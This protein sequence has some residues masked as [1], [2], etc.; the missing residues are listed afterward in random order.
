[1]ATA[2]E[3]S[4]TL[5]LYLSPQL[6]H[7][8]IVSTNSVTDMSVQL[9]V[10]PVGCNA[11]PASSEPLQSSVVSTVTSAVEDDLQHANDD[12]SA[13]RQLGIRVE[14]VDNVSEHSA[15]DCNGSGSV[16]NV[17]A[18]E[19]AEA[20]VSIDQS[21]GPSKVSHFLSVLYLFTL[22]FIICFINSLLILLRSA[23]VLTRR[24]CL[25][26]TYL[27]FICSKH[28]TVFSN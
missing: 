2:D 12:V 24:H 7:V 11:L 4:S 14:C 21:V 1:M 19:S 13:K 26:W 23:F 22:K 15:S 9:N 16:Q 25:F 20:T 3:A 10:E 5:I 18:I 27:Y 28:S 8:P 6:H 17:L